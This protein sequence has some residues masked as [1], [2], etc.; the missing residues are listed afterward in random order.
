[1]T[2]L[3]TNGYRSKQRVRVDG[4]RGG[5]TV[6]SR[7]TLYHLLGN[8]VYIGKTRHG[9]KLYEGQHKAI[10][11]QKTWDQTAELLASNRVKRRTSHDVASGRILLGLLFDDQENHFPDLMLLL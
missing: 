2:N 9:G 3:K 10:I 8:P 7:G 1:M 6:L 4:R 5:G 11:D